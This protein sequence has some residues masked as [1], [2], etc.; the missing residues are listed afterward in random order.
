MSTMG[1]R[2]LLHLPKG[3]K[4]IAR[5]ASRRDGLKIR[6]RYKDMPIQVRPRAPRL[7]SL[8]LISAGGIPP[9]ES[10]IKKLP[11]DTERG[12]SPLRADSAPQIGILGVDVPDPV[13]RQ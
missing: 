9:R 12:R 13:V 1:G 7:G 2:P 3:P 5:V 8:R 11:G 4:I 10:E 6:C